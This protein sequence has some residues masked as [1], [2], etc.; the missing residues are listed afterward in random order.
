MQIV[1]IGCGVIGAAIAYELSL[2][3]GLKITVIEQRPPHT[4]PDGA[5]SAAL[6]VNMG[7]ISKKLKGQAWELRRKTVE[8]YATLI[9]ELETLTARKI[10]FNQQGIL[11]LVNKED[12]I[13]FWQELP[14]VRANQRLKIAFWDAEKIKNSCPQIN[15]NHIQAGVY[16]P[17][18]IQVNPVELTLALIDGAE[19]N[20]VKFQ[21]GVNVEKLLSEKRETC[22]GIN[23]S[24]GVINFDLLII[25]AGLGST[26]LTTS[27]S[28]PVT[29]EPVLGQALQLQL[30]KPLGN[31]NFQPVIT[32]DDVHIVPVENN[33]YWIGATVEFPNEQGEVKAEEQL[34]EEV[35]KKAIAFCPEL[36]Q[37][38]VIKTWTGLRPRPVNRPAP[39]IEYLKGYDNVLLA[40]GHYRNGILLA[41]VTALKIRDLVAQKSSLR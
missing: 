20:G 4:N 35:R 25:A 21:F 36:A 38:K 3:S 41:P 16:S 40:T 23:T 17:D 15:W 7:I 8:R 12:D 33:S 28:Q 27:L 5:T 24:E 29:I 9:P 34:L 11:L 2:I 39:I 22:T 31:T 1:I 13:T 19:K 30:E 6:G 14:E 10:P 26:S 18:D 32:G 37:G